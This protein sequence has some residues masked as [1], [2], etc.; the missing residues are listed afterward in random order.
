MLTFDDGP[1][2]EHTPEVLNLLKEYN[3]TATFFIIGKNIEGNES[4][5]KSIDAAGHTLGNHSFSHS[6]FIDFK[7]KKAF[8]DEVNS[9]SKLVDSIIGKKM[10]L[11]RPPYGV[12]TPNLARAAKELNLQVIGWNVRSLDTTNDSQEV[13][14]NR[15]KQKLKPGSI[16]LLHDTSSKS[17]N[18]L[19]HLLQHCAA[20]GIKIVNVENALNI[21]AYES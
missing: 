2:N 7:S 12:T 6:F 16:V 15:I 3:A 20:S 19:R 9:T 10:K 11:F 8:V 17:V 1:N 18:V 14:L 5:V 4:I 21:K 13:I